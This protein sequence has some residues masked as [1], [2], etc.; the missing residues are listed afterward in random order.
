MKLLIEE[1]GASNIANSLLEVSTDN[2]FY[3]KKILSHLSRT[4]RMQGLALVRLGSDKTWLEAP[5]FGKSEDEKKML[6]ES[7][8]KV[9]YNIIFG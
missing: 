3:T 1:H 2:E 5:A 9:K 8:R 7:L 4:G 6:M